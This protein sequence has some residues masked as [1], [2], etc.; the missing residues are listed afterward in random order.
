[1]LRR[2]RR[3]L[4]EGQELPDLILV[5]GGRG[6]LSSAAAALHDLGLTH[7][8]HAGLAKREEEI[9]PARRSRAA[10]AS[11]E[12][13]GAPPPRESSGRGPSVRHHLPPQESPGRH[14]AVRPGRSARHRPPAP[15]GAP[16]P[17]RQPSPGQGSLRDGTRR[18]GRP[19]RS[20]SVSTPVF[21]PWMWPTARRIPTVHGRNGYETT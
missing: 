7:I 17:L 3:V 1:M 14:P 11:P 16:E 19:P 13:P 15:P 18:N 8:P 9:F 21:T 5:D 4:T 12:L 20:R 2:Y 6:Q 10:A